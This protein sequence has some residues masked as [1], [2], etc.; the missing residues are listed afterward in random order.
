MK[1]K[2]EIMQAQQILASA[3]AHDVASKK[4]KMLWTLI[5][6]PS[7]LVLSIP[8]P[9]YDSVID[10]VRHFQPQSQVIMQQNN[11]I[12]VNYLVTSYEC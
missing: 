10:P 8:S 7:E 6:S 2:N 3:Q 9:Y 4:L 5:R 1:I 11:P 12:H